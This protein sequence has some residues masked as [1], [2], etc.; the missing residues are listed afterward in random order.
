VASVAQGKGLP[1]DFKK[2]SLPMTSEVKEN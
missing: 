1:N 2:K